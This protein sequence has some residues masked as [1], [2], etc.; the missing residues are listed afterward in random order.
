[1]DRIPQPHHRRAAVAETP[2]SPPIKGEGFYTY[3][4]PTHYP[5]PPTLDIRQCFCCYTWY[6]ISCTIRYTTLYMRPVLISAPIILLILLGAGCV[7]G[8][9]TVPGNG[10][11]A[12]TTT[13]TP[14]STDT[15]DTA[16]W[17]DFGVIDTLGLRVYL[18]SQYELVATSSLPVSEWYAR[19]GMI[20]CGEKKNQGTAIFENKTALTLPLLSIVRDSPGPKDKE[21]G[22]RVEQFTNDYNFS[23]KEALM[24]T[25]RTKGYDLKN[26][27]DIQD[28]ITYGDGWWIHY[29][30]EGDYEGLIVRTT[31]LYAYRL[32]YDQ[33]KN[34]VN[35]IMRV[36]KRLSLGDYKGSTEDIKTTTA[37]KEVLGALSRIR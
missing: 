27:T 1:M 34:D 30:Y 31:G 32:I 29:A 2:P 25:L 14:T 9:R 37:Y 22:K 36:S 26:F 13:G 8:G 15:I 28:I 17:K 16:D 11:V 23:S 20:P 5:H 33:E 18:P 24:E 19:A 3:P 7:W 4:H 35:S 12:T 10:G 6:T 21:C